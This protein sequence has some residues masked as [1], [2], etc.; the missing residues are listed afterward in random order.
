MSSGSNSSGISSSLATLS[1]QPSYTEAGIASNAA[2][3]LSLKY[4][5]IS[6][7]ALGLLNNLVVMAVVLKVK[8]LRRQ[9]RN[10]FIFHQSLAD[11][12]SA[13]F[14]IAIASKVIPKPLLVSFSIWFWT[15]ESKN[16]LKC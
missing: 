1:F 16:F 15:Q 2:L 8:K 6:V 10:W 13:G 3:R 9:A 12:L 4:A 5:F 11:F 7:G 14:I